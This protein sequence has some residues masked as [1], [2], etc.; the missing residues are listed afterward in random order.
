M[1][2]NMLKNSIDT[3]S[4]KLKGMIKSDCEYCDDDI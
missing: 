4:Y 1:N 3:H 2:T